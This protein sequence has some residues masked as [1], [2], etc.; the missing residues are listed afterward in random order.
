MSVELFPRKMVTIVVSSSLEDRLKK[1][2]RGAGACG[3]TYYTVRGEGESGPQTGHLA[4]DSS[5]LFMVVLND[6]KLGGF[7]DKLKSMKDCGYHL[8]VFV[9]DT[10]VMNPLKF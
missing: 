10:Q 2:I 7:L 4:G 9:S 5:T 3:F 6:E 1:T 8:T